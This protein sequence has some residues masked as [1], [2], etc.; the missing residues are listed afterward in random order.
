MDD[1]K[2]PVTKL[3]QAWSSGDEKAHDE[4]FRIVYEQLRTLARRH[5]RG[6]RPGHT[7]SATALVHE[8]YLR[9][10]DADIPW[11][12]RAHFF[13]ISATVMRRILVDHAK[14]RGRGKRGAGAPMVSLE[15]NLVVSA[16]PDPRIVLVDEALQRLA[17][18]DKRKAQ[19][20]ELSFFS[21]L[22]LEE[23]SHVVGGSLSA[24]HRELTFAKA[25]VSRE[26][27]PG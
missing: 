27:A 16:E 2:T 3:L 4:L 25:W 6:E 22:T 19:I 13:A 1:T 23:T 20:F 9:L 26:I 11:N 24:V 7:L 15:D 12:H 17:E 10:A 8:A 14:R 5:I 18:I 21:G